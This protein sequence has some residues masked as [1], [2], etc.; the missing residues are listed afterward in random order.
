[1]KMESKKVRIIFIPWK[2]SCKNVS[3]RLKDSEHIYLYVA[4][5]LRIST[6]AKMEYTC[7]QKSSGQFISDKRLHCARHEEDSLFLDRFLW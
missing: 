7:K 4:H 5:T 1:M 6:S 3:I 2:H